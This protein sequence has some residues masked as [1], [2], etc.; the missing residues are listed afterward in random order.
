MSG[1]YIAIS[2]MMASGKT[3]LSRVLANHLG[4]V[5]LPEGIDTSIPLI[6][7]VTGYPKSDNTEATV[8]FGLETLQVT[9]E[10]PLDGTQPPDTTTTATDTFQAGSQLKLRKAQFLI[11]IEKLL[12]DQKVLISLYRMGNDPEDTMTGSA[13]IEDVIVDAYFW[14]P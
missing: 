2:G 10:F 7:T 8:K 14:K 13:V 4:W 12:P 9:G 1:L 3:T 11:P 5:V 6:L